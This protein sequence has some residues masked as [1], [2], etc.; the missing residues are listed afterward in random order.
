MD[1][2]WP[3]QCVELTELSAEQKTEPQ[4]KTDFGSLAAAAA[5]VSWRDRCR[6]VS[7]SFGTSGRRELQLASWGVFFEDHTTRQKTSNRKVSKQ[8]E[9]HANT[10]PADVTNVLYGRAGYKLLI[11]IKPR[12]DSLGKRLGAFQLLE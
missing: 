2:R 11:T 4:P 12:P 8:Q 10:T 6:I 9:R 5:S 1:G 7:S 3:C